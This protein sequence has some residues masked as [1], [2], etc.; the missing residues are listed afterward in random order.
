[1]ITWFSH[2]FDNLDSIARLFDLFIA[3][4]PLMPLYVGV[5]VSDFVFE[6]MQKIILHFR[7]KLLREVD[8]EYSAIHTFLC[9]VPQD[10]P[11]EPIIES[12]LQLYDKFP[13]D[14]L[15]KRA[16]KLKKTY[17]LCCMVLIVQVTCQ[18]LPF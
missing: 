6:L 8:C 9:N 12:A 13:P 18:Q 3:S 7:E 10:I 5:A 16:V 15:Q 17:A 1:M 11:L 4:H 2:G 14:K